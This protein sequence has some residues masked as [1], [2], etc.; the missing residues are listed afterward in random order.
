MYGTKRVAVFGD[1]GG[2]KSTLA[3]ELVVITGLPLT[4]VDE[5]QYSAGGV[6]VPH[7]NYA[8]AHAALLVQDEWIVDGL[9]GIKL[10]W[11]WLEAADTLIHVNL[12]LAVHAL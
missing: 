6:K 2:G 5:L 1:A 4:V 12:P 7:E 3:R 10:L 11:E 8:Q 9:S